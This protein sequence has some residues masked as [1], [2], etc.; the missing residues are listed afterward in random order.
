MEREQLREYKNGRQCTGIAPTGD[1]QT[2]G[3]LALP[4]MDAT[5]MPTS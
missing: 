1:I 5:I 2:D 3:E 4:G